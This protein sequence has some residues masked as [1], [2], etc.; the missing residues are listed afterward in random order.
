MKKQI[1]KKRLQ[2]DNEVDKVARIEY[3]KVKN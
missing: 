3:N 2:P 1:S